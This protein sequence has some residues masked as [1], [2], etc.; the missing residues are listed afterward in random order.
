MIHSFLVLKL[1]SA[2]Y[3]LSCSLNGQKNR[4]HSIRTVSKTQG[5]QTLHKSSPKQKE[6][7]GASLH[8]MGFSAWS[9]EKKDDTK[10]RQILAHSD[11]E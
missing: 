8:M 3:V 11:R 2:R 7:G 5:M 9:P 1:I 6:R 4:Y 10:G